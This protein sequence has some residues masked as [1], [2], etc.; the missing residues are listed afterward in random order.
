MEL[1]TQ[2]M[3][4]QPATRFD[5]LHHVVNFLSEKVE[6]LVFKQLMSQMKIFQEKLEALVLKNVTE[7]C[8]FREEYKF[9]LDYCILLFFCHDKTC[10]ST[11]FFNSVKQFATTSPLSVSPPSSF[12]HTETVPKQPCSFF[13]CCH[14][15]FPT[16][17]WQRH[18]ASQLCSQ[19]T[20]IN[21]MVC[22]I[23]FFVMQC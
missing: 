22:G 14:Q 16:F 8:S 18:S 20:P 19:T 12:K 7:S 6:A 5:E 4:Y 3:R 10:S 17:C 23:L 13:K 2:W 9:S 11:V 15:H 1:L 21:L